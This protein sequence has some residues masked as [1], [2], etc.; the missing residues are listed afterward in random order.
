[1]NAIESRLHTL[2]QYLPELTAPSDLG[3]FWERACG[4]ASVKG[5]YTREQVNYPFLQVEVYKI[6]LEGAANTPVHAW[7]L[8]PPIQLSRPIPCVVTFH[9]YTG[10]KGQPEDHA[11]WLLMGYAVL[12][13]DVRGQ[14][15]ETGNALS[16][17]YGMTKGWMTQGIL[18]PETAYYRAVTID[19]LRAV[20]CAMEQPEIDPEKVLVFGVSQG[21]GLAL[22][23]SALEPRVRATVAHVPNMC[24]MDLGMLQSTGSLTEAAEFV[25]R[26]PDRLNDVLRTL[27]Y[28]DIMNLADRITLPVRVTVGLKDTVCL[29]ETIFAA[30]NRIVSSRKSIEAYPFMGHAVPP[31]FHRAAH[32]FFSEL[33]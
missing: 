20:R 31:G 27:S 19:G 16:Q 15:G 9:G 32:T 21:G 10:S 30:Y 12:A 29:P 3:G 18:D 4:E 26:F 17:E 2:Q 23:V 6:I 1:M 8:L 13:I 22:L 28:F 24:H 7:Y 14:G 25:T 11:A 5:R 33:L